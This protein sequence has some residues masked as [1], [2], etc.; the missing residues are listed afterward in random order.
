MSELY[1]SYKK[2]YALKKEEKEFL[3]DNW[4]SIHL[5]LS[6]KKNK[7]KE[8]PK[9][10]N[11]RINPDEIEN[12]KVYIEEAEE[13]SDY[14]RYAYLNEMYK[15]GSYN[16]NLIKYAN[17][18][19]PENA[20]ELRNLLDLFNK[21]IKIDRDISY[22]NIAVFM[23]PIKESTKKI[24]I[25]PYKLVGLVH[26]LNKISRKYEKSLYEKNNLECRRLYNDFLHGLNLLRNKLDKTPDG[27]ER[28]ELVKYKK[29][30]RTKTSISLRE[31][32]NNLKDQGWSR[33]EIEALLRAKGNF[34]FSEYNSFLNEILGE[35]I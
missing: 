17:N 4:D 29:P 34:N 13:A 8:I 21:Y 35:Q 19:N 5:I 28:V 7:K 26:D 10:N 18:Y 27:K 6:S 30:M 24:L 12:S 23:H 2:I 16:N 32:I 9:Q 31:E 22:S 11:G 1:E 3:L 15:S 20:E 25:R 14:V 33:S